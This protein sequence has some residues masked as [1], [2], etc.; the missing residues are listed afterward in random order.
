M[1]RIARYQAALVISGAW[2]ASS[3]STLYEELDW[4]TLSDRRMCRPILQIHRISGNMTPSYL[5]PNLP[6]AE[7]RSVKTFVTLFVK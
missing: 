6:I 2:R 4:E 5:P 7:P 3:Y 1:D